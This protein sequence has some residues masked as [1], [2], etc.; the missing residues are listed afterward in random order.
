M[1]KHKKY[2]IVFI[3]VFTF[4][5]IT[6]MFHYINNINIYGDFSLAIYQNNVNISDKVTVK[7]VS[8]FGREHQLEY[9]SGRVHS[10]TW[11]Y[12]EL[13]I[14]IPDSV[15]KDYLYIIP[16]SND[17]EFGF[18][19]EIILEGKDFALLKYLDEKSFIDKFLWF[20][21]FNWLNIIRIII[22]TVLFCLL[23]LLG[24]NSLKEAVKS[25]Q[26]R[27]I[28]YYLYGLIFTSAIILRFST[29]LTALLA[30]DYTG[31][32]LPVYKF[33]LFGSFDHHEWAY[34]YPIF[35]ISVLS[36]FNN[37]NLIPVIQ[38]SLS[39]LSTL[40]FI[41]LIEKYYKKRFFDI[42]SEIAFTF[43]CVFFAGTLLLNGNFIIHEKS[44][45]HEGLI[46]PSVLIIVSTLFIYFHNTKT[47]YNILLYTICVFLLFLISLLQYRFTPGFLIIAVILLFHESFRTFK[48]LRIKNIIPISIFIILYLIVFIPE[49][50]LINKYD[51]IVPSFAYTQFMYSNAPTVLK[52]IEEGKSVEPDYDTIILKKHI[53]ETLTSPKE[54]YFSVLGYDFDNLK[55]ELARPDLVI[56]IAKKYFPD[57]KLKK[58]TANMSRNSELSEIYNNY[59]K[60][61]A[62]LIIKERP[63]E[64]IKKT[65]RQ[66]SAFFFSNKINYVRYPENKIITNPENKRQPFSFCRYAYLEDSFGFNSG[67]PV[68]INLPKTNGGYFLLLSFLIRTF[69]I[70]SILYTVWLILKKPFPYFI[71]SL[72]IVIL[73]TIFTIAVLHSFDITRYIHTLI[74]FIVSYILFCGLSF[75]KSKNIE[76][77]TNDN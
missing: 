72:L 62:K 49:R 2:L 30:F 69:L 68:Q 17:Y 26:I 58:A 16:Y 75:I 35:L 29:P 76:P 8:F 10:E 56:H 3:L 24:F 73:T 48:I 20:F 55:Y 77:L 27:Q 54:T 46:I 40:G 1:I 5:V 50:Y 61:W 52:I 42:K 28:R 38:H 25:Y 47:K 4:S 31:H 45:H 57:K 64:P 11:Y 19:A 6:L 44:V 14:Y 23:L 37:I 15:E 33:F 9:N 41:I 7:G 18:E 32:I 13:R 71:F 12:K 53:I 51:K 70:L 60:N 59:Y 74:P 36:L 63:S 65:I 67:T 34:P 21:P 22:F 66:L 43:L 39:I